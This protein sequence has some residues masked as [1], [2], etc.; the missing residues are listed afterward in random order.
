M[1]YLTGTR[2]YRLYQRLHQHKRHRRRTLLLLQIPPR[3][4]NRFPTHQMTLNSGSAGTVRNMV[5]IK[6]Y[7]EKLQRVSP[8]LT[9]VH[10]ILLAMRECSS[11]LPAHGSRRVV[12]WS[13]MTILNCGLTL[14]NPYGLLR[15][16]FLAAAPVHGRHAAHTMKTLDRIILLSDLFKSKKYG[17]YKQYH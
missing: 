5:L 1:Y 13:L 2:S 17:E 10:I 7:C 4:L 9:P 15:S 11:F 14:K 6:T 3:P 12:R 16:K 8:A